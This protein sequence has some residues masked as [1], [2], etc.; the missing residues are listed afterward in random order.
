MSEKERDM[1]EH[2][3]VWLVASVLVI[4]GICAADTAKAGNAP[5]TYPFPD[6]V[7]TLKATGPHPSLGDHARDF[8]RLVGTWDVEYTDFS[9]DGKAT[10]RTGE[11]TVGWVMDGR[12]VQDVWIVN[13][14][15]TRRDREV[16]TDLLCFDPK[17]RTWR[18]TSVDPQN[19]SILGLTGGAVGDDRFVLETQDINSKEN[20]WS[21]NDIRSD[22]F[23]WRDEA[24]S[25]GGKTWRLLSEYHMTRRG[26][27][28]TVP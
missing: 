15:G 3:A 22:S 16:Y 24:S 11:F 6:M 18:A 14:S 17:S 19:G 5:E 13:P 23:V 26:A 10:H 1:K 7:T 27:G 9:K 21:F 20:R 4:S 8:G 25:D 12:A 2:Y 28:P